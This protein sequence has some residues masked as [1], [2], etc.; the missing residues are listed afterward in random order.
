MQD[1]NN[2]VVFENKK[3]LQIKNFEGVK[4]EV[5]ALLNAMYTPF[6]ILNKEDLK[7]SKEIRASL[8][9]MSKEINDNKIQWVKDMTERIQSQTKEI[10]DLIKEKSGAYDLKIKEYEASLK[11]EEVKSKAKYQLIIEFETKEDLDKFTSKLPKKLDFKV[12]EK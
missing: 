10:C 7:K 6:E 5:S 4:G 2:L 1:L 8:N 3:G 12:K 9:K 11:G